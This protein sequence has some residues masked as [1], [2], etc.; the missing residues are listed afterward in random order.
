MPSSVKLKFLLEEC[1][2]KKE[3]SESTYQVGL[4]PVLGLSGALRRNSNTPI[5][6][7]R[8]GGEVNFLNTGF[9]AT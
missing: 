6:D 3:S 5:F 1:I 8:Y 4:P 7:G 2:K 9:D